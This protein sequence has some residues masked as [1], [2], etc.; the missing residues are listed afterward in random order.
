MRRFSIILVLC[1]WVAMFGS[2]RAFAQG[3][4]GSTGPLIPNNFQSLFIFSEQ[5]TSSAPCNNTIRAVGNSG[6]PCTI[7][8]GYAIGSPLNSG[9]LSTQVPAGGPIRFD[10]TELKKSWGQAFQRGFNF[11][12]Y[13]ILPLALVAFGL[14]YGFRYSF[15]FLSEWLKVKG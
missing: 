9:V 10:L 8:N 7:D 1:A 4:D 13:K 12:F 2:V 11:T 5:Q 6:I 15:I 14:A 3:S